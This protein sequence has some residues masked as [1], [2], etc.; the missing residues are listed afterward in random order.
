MSIPKVVHFTWKTK[1]LTKFAQRTWDEWQRTHPDFELKL[2]DD[3]DCR[4]LIAEHYPE[5]LSTYDGYRSGIFRADAWRFFVLHHEGG[6]YADLDVLPKA[7]IDELIEDTECFVGAEPE[8]HVEE[9]DGLYRGMPFVLCNAFMGSVPGHKFWERCMGAMA[10][11][12]ASNDVVDATGPRLVNGVALRA[13]KDER[14]D[15]LLPDRWSPQSGHG[16]FAPMSDA[17][18]DAVEAEFTVIGR[19]KPTLVSH[20]WRN[21]WFMPFFY[22]GPEFWKVPNKIQWWWRRQTNPQIAQT[23]FTATRRIFHKQEFARFTDWPEVFVAV[24]LGQGG[25]A[26]GTVL[27]SI[28][29]DRAKLSFGLF[30][31]TPEVIGA[32]SAKLAADG[33]GF[34]VFPATEGAAQQHNAMLVAAG[35]KHCL[36]LDG[37]LVELAAGA[38]EAL[39]GA[40]KGVVTLDVVSPT[41][42]SR[43]EDTLLY[44]DSVFKGLYRGGARENAFR[45]M[46]HPG[47]LPLVDLRPLDVAPVTIVGA[48]VV[49]VRADVIAAG[50]RFAVEPVKFHRDAAGLA[51]AARDAGFDVAALPNV[52]A[53]TG[54]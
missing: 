45:R 3:A 28:T 31:G 11:C 50:V 38:V 46:S 30:G 23:K 48:D 14:P 52:T 53:V 43:N 40:D 32:V 44:S 25:D 4:A 51:I 21:S 19:G 2:W 29:Y 33:F 16:T 36:I 37:R 13:P 10:R 6:I 39:V 54:R 22:K 24:D 15:V 12:A 49:F 47:G 9:N 20:L 34:E 5:H 42:E 26:I 41:G 17:Y 7:R 35:S 27:T 8:R 1:T 18:A